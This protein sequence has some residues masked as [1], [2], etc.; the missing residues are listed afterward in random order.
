MKPTRLF[1]FTLLFISG[2][3]SPHAFAQ[4]Y[5]RWELPEGAKMRLGKGRIEN[6]R[7]T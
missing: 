4:D 5:I 3:F 2:L 6:L 7:G 1:I